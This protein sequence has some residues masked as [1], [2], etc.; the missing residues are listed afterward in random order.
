M[1]PAGDLIGRLPHHTN[2]MNTYYF[3]IPK[4]SV[5]EFIQASSLDE[6]KES[7][8]Q[9]WLPFLSQMEWLPNDD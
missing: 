9:E 1:Q 3:Y 5:L 8:E 6:A 7:T 4:A 2:F